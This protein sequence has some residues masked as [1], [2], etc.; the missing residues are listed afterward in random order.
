MRGASSSWE[1]A[2]R[3]TTEVTMPHRFVFDC[4]S[5]RAEMHVDAAIRAELLADGCV[6]CRAPVTSDA[7]SAPVDAETG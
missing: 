2:Y 6:L 4:P 5:C 7:F 1:R 3:P